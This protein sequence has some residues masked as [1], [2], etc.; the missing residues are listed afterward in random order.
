MPVGRQGARGR[1]CPGNG[2]AGVGMGAFWSKQGGGSSQGMGKF[3]RQA[4]FGLNLS[5]LKQ[6]KKPSETWGPDKSS[7]LE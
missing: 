7:V 2:V 1:L 5:H 4:E 3:H 6:K